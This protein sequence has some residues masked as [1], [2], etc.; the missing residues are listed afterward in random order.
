MET[1]ACLANKSTEHEA[2][3]ERCAKL[4]TEI[5]F[6]N[7]DM[8]G[9]KQDLGKFN[10]MLNEDRATIERLE[11]EAVARE[12]RNASLQKTSSQATI[13]SEGQRNELKRLKEILEPL[14]DLKGW[15]KVFT[16][17]KLKIALKEMR[18]LSR[19]EIGV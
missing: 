5:Y 4:E 1:R 9:C 7:Y 16:P 6:K 10:E 11:A 14:Q 18:G 3:V 8:E 2:S 19:E 12:S 13:D 17:K 15:K